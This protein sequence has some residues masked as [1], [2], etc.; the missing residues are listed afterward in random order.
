MPTVVRSIN[1]ECR[2]PP[3]LKF[4]NLTLEQTGPETFTVTG[5]NG[6]I[7]DPPKT[8]PK[9]TFTTLEAA[10]REFDKVAKS[11]LK[12]SPPYTEVA[13][14]ASQMTVVT[15]EKTGWL[16]MTPVEV[17]ESLLETYLS[18]G[19][20]FMQPKKNGHRRM[21]EVFQNTVTGT[22]KSGGMVPVSLDIVAELLEEC[23]RY[24]PGR[25]VFDGEMIGLEYHI[26]DCLYWNSLNLQN[27]QAMV[28]VDKMCRINWDGLGPK[29]DRLVKVVPSAVS[30]MDKVRMLEGLRKVN[31][32]GVIFKSA[33]SPYT[34][35]DSP[36]QVKI[37][38]WEEADVLV[39]MRPTGRHSVGM[40]V[41]NDHGDWVG[42]GNC[43]IGQATPLPEGSTVIRVKYLYYLAGLVQPSYL[44]PSEKPVN[45]CRVDKLKAWTGEKEPESDEA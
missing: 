26:F 28:R 45:E 38:F 44:G 14:K 4:Y 9:G 25:Y 24:G 36:A 17:P 7:G 6:R 1:L 42:V 8:Q 3:H 12:G 27:E 15:A 39:D 16:P 19:T 41:L 5:F 20:W 22:N 43:T 40:L 10:E 2:I 21:I 13:G 33:G 30:R 32:E 37:K 35:G 29:K 11:K 18:N 23:R 34:P 31:A